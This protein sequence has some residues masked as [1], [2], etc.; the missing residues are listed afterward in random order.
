MASSAR[1]EVRVAPASGRRALKVDESGRVR[2]AVT[3]PPERGRANRA[4]VEL[5]AERLGVAK[6][7]VRIVK[8]LRARDKLIEVEGLSL[9]EAMRRLSADG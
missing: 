3:Q 2:V 1:F 4:V 7:G 6:R 9:E 5:L 8:G